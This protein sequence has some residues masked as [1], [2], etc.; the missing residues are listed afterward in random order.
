MD[1]RNMFTVLLG[2]LTTLCVRLG[3]AKPEKSEVLIFSKSDGEYVRFI[4]KSN[5]PERSAS[6]S[7]LQIEQ[8]IAIHEK[9][10][11]MHNN[12]ANFLKFVKKK[13]AIQSDEQFFVARCTGDNPHTVNEVL[14]NT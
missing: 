5:C 3:I 11:A 6:L 10:A 1:R 13:Y 12:S 8:E 9:H 7:E 14:R 4:L 2:V